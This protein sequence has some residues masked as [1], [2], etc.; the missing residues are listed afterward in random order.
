[1]F[2]VDLIYRVLLFVKYSLQSIILL[3]MYVVLMN[4]FFDKMVAASLKLLSEMESTSVPSNEHA[5][6]TGSNANSSSMRAKCDPAW[7]H[8][9]E[10]LKEGKSS[11]RRIHCGKSYKG[12][13]INRMKRHLARIKGDVAACVAACMAI[14]YDVRFQMVE[15]LK[16]ISKSK[17]QTKKDQEA[18]NYLPLEDSPKFEDVQEI[19]PRGRGLGRGNRSGPS[20]F[21]PRSNLGKRKVGDIDKY[22]APRTT[23]GAQPSIKSVLVGKEKKWRVDMFVARRMYD[24]CIPINTVNSSYY[25][26]MFNAIASYGP[27]Y[28]GLN[29]HALRVPLLRDA[30]REVQ[31]IVDS[32]CSYWANTGCTIMTNGWTDTRHRTLINFLVYCPKGIILNILLMLLNWLR[33]LLI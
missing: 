30:K 32:H 8:V 17:E 9:T 24:A 6:T 23:L 22:F 12:G 25:Q 26:R 19:T 14:P 18:S 29:Y 10:E 20:D 5:S 27:R 33:M 13:G 2:I 21:P 28:R 31:L 3:I 16:E 4:L 1:M 15:N 11:Y 7:D